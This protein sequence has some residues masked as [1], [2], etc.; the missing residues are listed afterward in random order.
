ME[1][2][3]LLTG[4][5][6][7]LD[8]VPA[9]GA[10]HAAFVR[11]AMAHARIPAI[12]PSAASSMPGVVA[13][14]T[15]EDLT[16]LRMPA[17]ENLPDGLRRPLLATDVVRFIGE[18][19]AVVVATTRA[20]ALDAAET[21]AVEYDPLPAVTDPVHAMEEDAP[22]LFPKEG[23]NVV[24]SLRRSPHAQPLEGADVV[25]R[26]T[27]VNQRVAP[28]PLEVNGA[29]AVPEGDRL[30]LWL[31]CQATHYS[32]ATIAQ[33]IEIGE[34]RIRVRT[35][36]VG[37]GFGAKIPA[38]A[39]QAV[40]AA[41]AIRLRRPVRYS[42][43]RSENLV[44]MT[45]GRDQLQEVEL[46]A[47]RDGR[48]VGLRAR[49]VADLG[50]Y[51]DEGATL[52]E[53]T[54]MM[55]VGPYEIPRLDLEIRA[56]VTN[57]TPLGA[58][59]GAGRP[60]AT[61]LIE[62]VLDVLAD[63]LGV[64]PAA[65]R[66]RNYIRRFP[67][68]T[69]AGARYDTGDYGRSLEEALRIAG[70]DA[71]R[72]EQAERL[73]RDDSALLGIGIGSYV[74]VTGWGS[75]YA[76]VVVDEDGAVRLVTGAS[77]QGQ[78]HETAFAQILSD[79]LAV[80]VDSV[81]VVHSDTEL[82]PR[83][84]GT[85]GSRSLQVAGSAVL[86]AGDVVV[87]RARSVAAR[88]LEVEPEDV[89]LSDDG[90]FEVAGVP[91]AGPTWSDV[92]RAA[93]EGGEPLD[94]E[95]DFEIADSTYPFGTHV[96]VVEVDA[97]TGSTRLLRHV[98]VDDCGT[99][100]N[101][102][103]V[104][105]QVHGGI[106]QGVAQALFEGVEY[107]E[108]GTPLTSNLTTY[109]FPSAAELPSFE[110]A[111]TETPTPMNPLGAKGIGEAGTIGAFPAVQN[112]IVDALAH[113]GVHHVDTPASPERV[114]RAIALARPHPIGG[115]V[116]PPPAEGPDRGDRDADARGLLDRRDLAAPIRE[117]ARGPASD[118]SGGERGHGGG[119]PPIR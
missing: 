32:R 111:T 103:L 87:E 112:A 104:E 22:L 50:A 39:E 119:A 19:V 89:A 105:G 117:L 62:R 11:S 45:H 7:Y 74:E 46:G 28:V 25:V 33:A 8:D 55:A 21:V 52:P 40:V 78:G 61:A 44:A 63:E 99:V 69:V 24:L 116:G 82:V 34:S 114:W 6:A 97:E 107:D 43:T 53:S 26:G 29:L 106:A 15:A 58:Y 72:D 56:V 35:A 66:R 95:L 98:A 70:Y 18:P 113:L 73:R 3:G 12:D 71:L 90:H 75:E 84:E 9:P 86:R 60:E 118:G 27:F 13:V 101:P 96:A 10:L 110:T 76:R 80:P 30:T 20:L 109:C 38:Y 51:P 100:M 83:S 85:M 57:K 115:E 91:G 31:P 42:E 65:V 16:G 36:A 68:D 54:A 17:V 4:A 37:G 77:P 93:A 49:I 108:L 67:H 14:V 94:A 81:R 79:R 5:T 64:D 41:L 2:R 88:L 59:R 102:L 47:T 92:A 1:D 23:S 48:L